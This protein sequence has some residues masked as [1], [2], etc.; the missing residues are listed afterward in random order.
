MSRF[1]FDRPQNRARKGRKVK[2]RDSDD[3]SDDDDSD[4]DEEE[5]KAKLWEEKQEQ[6]RQQ[7]VK[8]A[9]DEIERKVRTL[10][11]VQLVSTCLL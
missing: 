6:N 5:K 10:T 9:Y 4:D 3:S 11:S 2:E 7:L 1:T 8:L